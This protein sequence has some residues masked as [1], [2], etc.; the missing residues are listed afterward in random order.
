MKRVLLIIV[1]FFLVLFAGCTNTSNNTKYKLSYEGLVENED[2]L[3]SYPNAGL[4]DDGEEL[5]IKV[6][7]VND[8]QLYVFL[9]SEKLQQF[10][11]ERIDDAYVSVFKFNMPENDLIVHLTSDQFYGKDEYS[12]SD[13]LW[14]VRNLEN[15]NISIDYIKLSL[16]D[17]NEYFNKHIYT[18]DENDLSSILDLF[19]QKLTRT[20]EQVDYNNMISYHLYDKNNNVVV[21][22]IIVDDCVLYQDFS[23][24]ELFKLA[25]N[26]E[27]PI[28]TGDVT[29]TFRVPPTN[30]AK[31]KVYKENEII[32]NDIWFDSFSMFEFITISKSEAGEA[33]MFYKIE[34]PYGD[35]EI[36]S[37]KRFFFNGEAYEIVGERDFSYWKILSIE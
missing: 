10:E 21:E 27:L 13:V 23:S 4:Y 19:K 1:L 24:S 17:D 6:H 26:F 8:G 18:A 9:N 35:I 3:Y 12:F 30:N 33:N 16:K 37:Y 32:S 29:Y 36:I 20:N 11:T 28:F 22:V 25:N 34:T 14:Q 2:I 31:V 15:N 7:V 5:V